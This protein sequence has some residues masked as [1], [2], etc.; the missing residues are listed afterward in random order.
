M[1]NILENLND[2][3]KLAVTHN[4]GPA[5]VL[6]GAGSG[7]T[8]VLTTRV[9]WLLAEHSCSPENILLVTFTNKAAKEMNDRVLK[10]TGQQ[11]SFSGTFHSLSARILRREAPRVG[12]SHSFSIYDANDQL[13]LIKQIYKQSSFDTKRYKPQVIK[14]IISQAKNEMLSWQEYEKLAS[15]HFQEFTA[16]VYKIY[17]H[18]LRLQNA[19][20]F[21]DLL[22]LTVQVLERNKDVLERYQSQIHHVLVDEYQDTN[23]AQYQ[24]T[25]LLTKP[26][27]NLYVVGDFSQSIY[28]WRGADYRNL[29]NLKND[30][31]DM[32]EYRLEQNYRSTQTILSAASQLIVGNTTH[33]VLNLWTNQSSNDDKITVI[34]GED[35]RDEAN[36]VADQIELNHIGYPYSAMA[37]LYRTNAQSRAFEEVFVRRGIPYQI[38][39]GTKFYERKEIKDLLAYLRL[40]VNHQDTVSLE[41]VE[42]IGKR[43]LNSFLTWKEKQ[44]NLEQQ[45]PYQIL[46]TIL[47][48]TNYKDIFDK[49]DPQDEARLDNIEELLNVAHQ[50]DDTTTFLENVA[51]IQD[52]QMLDVENE[53]QNNGVTL[54]SLHSAK[55]LEFPVVFIVGMEEGLL[56]H[57]RSIWNKEETEEERRLCYVGITRAKEKLY[58]SHARKRWQY[59]NGNYTSRSRFIN[60][61]S[62]DLLLDPSNG[63]WSKLGARFPTKTISISASG[64]RLVPDDD[65]LDALLNDELDIETFLRS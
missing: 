42:K 46:E 6:A 59:G 24:L 19:V 28:A 22:L 45:T 57:S 36:Q 20:D 39:G 31:P 13:S 50:F 58:F 35:D 63:S 52:D 64:R 30:F 37:I 54:M 48:V 12:L 5:V 47:S 18:Q 40:V 55:G 21:D 8:K 61:I 9:A 29:S 4:S 10:L 33:P 17:D 34:E 26:H 43:K 44:K 16:K 56:P 27:D 11:L 1:Q 38:V 23:K 41:R 51:L 32:R 15:D 2:Q 25:N 53:R 49:N 65:T 3:Q 60:E 62:D 14:N 7:K